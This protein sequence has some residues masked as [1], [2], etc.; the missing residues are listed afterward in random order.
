[1]ARKVAKSQRFKIFFFLFLLP[2]AYCL[3]PNAYCLLPPFFLPFLFPFIITASEIFCSA[4][5]LIGSVAFVP[6]IKDCQKNYA[7]NY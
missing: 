2:T 5:A 6:D 1:M 3:L 4:L 7:A